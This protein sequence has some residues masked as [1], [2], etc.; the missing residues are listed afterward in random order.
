MRRAP[1]MDGRLGDGSRMVPSVESTENP[2]G[3]CSPRGGHG[4]HVPRGESLARLT[5]DKA[6]S[7]PASALP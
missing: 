3:T 1:A 2:R 5:M 6:N 4:E 7:M